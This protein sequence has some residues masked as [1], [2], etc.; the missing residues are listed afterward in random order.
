MPV[1]PRLKSRLAEM[2]EWRR[3]LHAHPELG[4]EERRTSAF[5]AER[6]E[7]F[8]LRVHRGLATTG[9]VAATASHTAV[10]SVQPFSMSWIEMS[11]RT[12]SFTDSGITIRS[13]PRTSVQTPRRHPGQLNLMLAVV[14]SRI[15]VA[16]RADQE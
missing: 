10:N 7:S 1:H 12:T 3:D 14:E 15:R 11:A 4:F 16:L 5:V 13:P 9:V 2:T 8:G 6:L